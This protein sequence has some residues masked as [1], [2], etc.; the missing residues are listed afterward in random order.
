MNNSINYI[1]KVVRCLLLFI[2]CVP[3]IYCKTL[4]GYHIP[5]ANR[6]INKAKEYVRPHPE[7]L[8]YILD[9]I[10]IHLYAEKFIQGKLV[11]IELLA[12]KENL[13][14]ISGIVLKYQEADIPLKFMGW[15]YRGFIGIDPFEIVG[16]KSLYCSYTKLTLVENGGN[17][18]I[19]TKVDKKIENVFIFNI[20][21]G[22][23]QTSITY[24][25]SEKPTISKGVPAEEWKKTQEFIN[26]STL[27]KKEAFQSRL[28]DSIDNL[29]AHPRD[30]HYITASFHEKRIRNTYRI[31]NK[32]RSILNSS[33]Y[34]HTGTDLRGRVGAPIYAIAAGTVVLAEKCYLEGNFTL[35]DHGNN[36]FSGYMHQTKILTS[37]GTK[38]KA[39]QLIGQVGATGRVTGPHLHIFLRVNNFFIDPLSILSLPIRN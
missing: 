17:K 3:I 8:T 2:L 29:I 21:D 23:F 38:V 4:D 27:K 11:Y 19:V 13:K 26:T 15:G 12:S 10:T 22:G 24:F 35:I 5:V 18:T 9:D 34:H 14:D 32:E 6:F 16:S 37:K 25:N 7:H 31:V 36:I 20:G 1:H 39:G 33:F 30:L 28:E